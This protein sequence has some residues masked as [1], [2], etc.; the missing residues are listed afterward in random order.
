MTA[1]ASQFVIVVENSEKR[2]EEFRRAFVQHDDIAVFI[3][4]NVF[5]ACCRWFLLYEMGLSP[6]AVITNWHFD[7]DD[8][9]ITD[10]RDN[11]FKSGA[12]FL[13][14]QCAQITDEG[15]LVVYTHDAKS[16]E[17]GLSGSIEAKRTIILSKSHLTV[18]GLIKWLENQ[19]TITHDNKEPHTCETSQS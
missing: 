19:R 13:L 11:I 6:R 2:R 3:E 10:E 8:A 1:K 4:G 9:C 12:H 16:A 18:K 15:L 14:M 17:I 7:D 5:D